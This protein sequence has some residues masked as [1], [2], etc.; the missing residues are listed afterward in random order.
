VYCINV[1]TL[2]NT[3]CVTVGGGVGGCQESQEGKGP[4]TDKHLPQSSFTG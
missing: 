1:H 3:Q 4:Q 2:H